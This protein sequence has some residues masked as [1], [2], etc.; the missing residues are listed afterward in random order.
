MAIMQL[1][2]RQ[3]FAGQQVINRWSYL[4]TGTPAAVSMSFA[5]IDAFGLIPDT[6]TGVYPVDRP[7][8]QMRALQSTA[9][10]YIE[11]EAKNLYSVTDF[12]TRPFVANLF[13]TAGTDA[14]APFVSWGFR[15]NRVRTDVARGTKRL[16]GITESAV[17]GSGS[18]NTAGLELAQDMADRMTDVLLYDDEGNT[19]TFTPCVLGFEEYTTPKGNRA[20]KPYA[21]EAAQL[22]HTASGILWQP[23]EQVRSQVSRQVGRGQ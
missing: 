1:V 5:L 8:A 11:A 18:I 16:A 15:T 20:Y 2:I 12:Y 17:D 22:A 6:V 4:G 10:R 14:E 23:Y 21:T 3:L 13:G 9:L 19:L 7:F